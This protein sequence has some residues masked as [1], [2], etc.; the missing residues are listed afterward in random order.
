MS[1]KLIVVAIMGL[2]VRKPV[3]RVTDNER[4]KSDCSAT[5]TIARISK[6]NYYTFQIVN[7]KCADQT[8]RIRRLICSFVV[9]MQQSQVFLHR[10]PYLIQWSNIYFDLGLLVLQED[11]FVSHQYLGNIITN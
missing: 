5:E 10:G 11:T 6:L 3:Y 1:K 7:N 8:G 2:D 9:C 4:L